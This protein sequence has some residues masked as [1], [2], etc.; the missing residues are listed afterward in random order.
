MSNILHLC[1]LGP[2]YQRKVAT[3][4]MVIT[5]VSHGEEEEQ[6]SARRISLP[7]KDTLYLNIGVVSFTILLLRDL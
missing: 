2:T 7:D 4:R 3:G 5:E 6:D 1:V